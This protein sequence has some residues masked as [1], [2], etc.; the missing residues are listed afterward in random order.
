MHRY[1]RL[2]ITST[3]FGEYVLV[4]EWGRCGS[5]NMGHSGSLM[6]QWFSCLQEAQQAK[7]NLVRL[8]KRKG[9]QIV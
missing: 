2:Y 1:Y 7:E 8:K 9:Y 4:R 5:K 3:L 6:Q